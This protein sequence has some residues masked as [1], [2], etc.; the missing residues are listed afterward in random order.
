MRVE[1]EVEEVT[2]ENDDGREV[3]GVEVTCGRCGHTEESFGTSEAS[4]RRCCALLRERCPRGEG[5]FYKA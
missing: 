2:L 4:V 1:C 3:D 5:N